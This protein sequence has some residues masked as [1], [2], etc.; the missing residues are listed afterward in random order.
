MK[1]SRFLLTLCAA[2]LAVNLHAAESGPAGI[3]RL[4]GSD[5]ALMFSAAFGYGT[6]LELEV[7]ECAQ[8]LGSYE[9]RVASF[10]A[11]GARNA[12]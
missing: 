12:E 2:M 6:S 9:K 3:A 7:G 1:T 4:L 8:V 11:R 10:S 5:R